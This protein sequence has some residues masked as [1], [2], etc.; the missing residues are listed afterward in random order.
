MCVCVCACTNMPYHYIIYITLLLLYILP[1]SPPLN[2][3]IALQYQ[4]IPC[5]L[6]LIYLI[7]VIEIY[8]LN[9]DGI[10]KMQKY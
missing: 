3:L 6:I 5:L 8:R 2:Y 1:P 10:L 7:L 4:V 9:Q